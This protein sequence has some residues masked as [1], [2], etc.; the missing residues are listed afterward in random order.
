MTEFAFEMHV[1]S[2]LIA[3]EVPSQRVLELV[4]TPPSAVAA[5]Q[6][7][8]LN[9]GLVIDRSGSMSGDKL[10]YVKRAAIHVL[11][12][13]QEQDRV[14]VVAYD[15]EVT[16]VS[17]S[18]A[19]TPAAKA[20]IKAKIEAMRSGNMTNLSGGWLAGCQEVAAAAVEGH[21][22]RVL[23]LTDGLANVGI[24]DLEELGVHAGQLL[25]RGVPTSTFGV[26]RDFD[27]HLLEH[28]ANQG[29]GRYYYIEHPQQIPGIFEEEFRELA[30]VT[31]RNVQVTLGVPTGVSVEVLG[32]WRTEQD[33]RHWHLWLSDLAANQRRQVY[34]KLLTPPAGDQPQLTVSGVASGKGEG[35]E[36]LR[37]E[38]LLNLRYAPETEVQAAPLR[39]DLMERFGLVEVATRAA[40]ALK[41]ERKGEREQ[42]SA[43]LSMSLASSAPYLSAAIHEEYSGLVER[44]RRGL[45]E[46][47]RKTSHQRQYTTKQRRDQ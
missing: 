13:M 44:M 47:S 7:P 1:D 26:G 3:R 28:M 20:E 6:R 38:T 31:A 17:P 8:A 2:E 11:E 46:E 29:G 35:G 14:A 37:V 40:E 12:V 9:L 18:V 33:D 25:L 15:T 21:L 24:T 5:H 27:E 43:M 19:V 23:L 16:P 36:P 39:M 10:E 45:D 22:N 32:S 30:A 42:A 34:V 41:L 4:V